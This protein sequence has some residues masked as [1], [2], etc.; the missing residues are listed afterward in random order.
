MSTHSY[1]QQQMYEYIRGELDTPVMEEIDR[2]ISACQSCRQELDELKLFFGR[3]ESGYQNPSEARSPEF[4]N[5]FAD[6]TMQRIQSSAHEI[7][8]SPLGFWENIIE[9]IF[10]YRVP[11]LGLTGVMALAIIIFI[12]WQKPQTEKP[13]I[14]AE[15]PSPVDTSVAPVD[16]RFESYLRK[17]KTLLIGVT[18]MDLKN[19]QPI[20]ITT[21]QKVSHELVS[22]ARALQQQPPIT[23]HSGQLLSDLEKIQMQLANIDQNNP[24]PR[25]EMIRH[26][27]REDNLLF[28]IRMAES[29]YGHARFMN[30]TNT[31]S[32]G[33]K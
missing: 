7:K 25:I 19:D 18:N 24:I 11:A 20:D 8:K 17:S 14:V 33:R 5:E 27:I 28:K 29:V 3:T 2:H 30:A 26:G 10:T 4:W 21:E 16:K 15:Q 6:T 9:S 1:I 32:G 13:D 12:L 31:T 23:V 22:E